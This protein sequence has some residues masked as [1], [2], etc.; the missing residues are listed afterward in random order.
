MKPWERGIWLPSLQPY[1]KGWNKSIFSG[2]EA[3]PPLPQREGVFIGG[4]EVLPSLLEISR[5]SAICCV[6]T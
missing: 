6:S 5:R 1:S 3:V 4:A 2:V